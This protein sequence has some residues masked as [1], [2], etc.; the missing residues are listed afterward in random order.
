MKINHHAD[1]ATLMS[2]AAGAL[3]ESFSLVL[4][5]HLEQCGRCRERLHDAE[6]VGATLLD[7]MA[8]TPVAGDSLDRLWA[9]IDAGEAAPE[10]APTPRVKGLPAVLAPYLPGGLQGIRWRTVAPGIRQFILR[11][12]ESAHGTARLLSI[13]PG[14]TVRFPVLQAVD[15]S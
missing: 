13:A 2:Y 8:R 4:A 14:T 9:A 5:A 11:D 12:V 6:D 15:A 3:P 7:G 1:D 10:P